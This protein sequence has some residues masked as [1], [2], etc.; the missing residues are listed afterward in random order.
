VRDNLLLVMMNHEYGI[1]P[2]DAAQVTKPPC[3]RAA[4]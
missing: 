4:N 3:G 1:K 2:F